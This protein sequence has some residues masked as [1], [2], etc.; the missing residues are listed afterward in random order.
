MSKWN[1]VLD[2]AV[3]CHN[4]HLLGLQSIFLPDTA[5]L[6]GFSPKS[7]N[8]KVAFKMSLEVFGLVVKSAAILWVTSEEENKGVYSS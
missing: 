7:L 1:R 6:Q 2:L 8:N 4:T 3:T 5:S